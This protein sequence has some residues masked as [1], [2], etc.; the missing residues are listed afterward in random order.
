LLANVQ[1]LV[2]LTAGAVVSASP[3]VF[4][5]PAEAVDT[6]PS[7]AVVGGPACDS[8]FD[9]YNYPAASLR[10]C[11]ILT[12]PRTQE[13]GLPDGGKQYTDASG[14]AKIVY[15]VPPPN[16]DPVHA[17]KS[18]LAFYD[19]PQ[20]PTDASRAAQWDRRMAHTHF[21]SPPP[22][23]ASVPVMS[24]SPVPTDH[25]NEFG[26]GSYNWAGWEATST[27][28]IFT[29]AQVTWVEPQT[30]GTTCTHDAEA[31]WVG[32]GGD[33]AISSYNTE[34]AQDGTAVNWPA[35]N[36]PPELDSRRSRLGLLYS[37]RAD[38]VRPH[39]I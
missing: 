38:A 10:P 21:L 8:S 3:V 14:A 31:T 37:H 23:L 19:L 28:S 32:I 29:T 27:G 5:F 36:P 20:R 12:I 24:H 30:Y 22:F 11:G 33:T 9:P 15:K 25:N 2:R 6:V 7:V 35:I 26:T 17:T 1:R 34:L 4:V 16:F 39:W 18:Q 13:I